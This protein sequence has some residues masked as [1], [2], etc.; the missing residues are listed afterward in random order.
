[1]CKREKSA[2]DAKTCIKLKACDLYGKVRLI[3]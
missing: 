1:M 2:S 3:F